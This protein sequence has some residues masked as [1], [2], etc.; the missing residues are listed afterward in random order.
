MD[1]SAVFETTSSVAEKTRYTAPSRSTCAENTPRSSRDTVEIA[2]R[3]RRDRAEITPRSPRDR[4]EITP[5][6]RRDRTLPVELP[7]V[8]LTTPYPR[9][10]ASRSTRDAVFRAV[11]IS[12]PAWDTWRWSV[13]MLLLGHVALVCRVVVVG[14]RGVGLSC[15][16]LIGG[17]LRR[18]VCVI[19]AISMR[20]RC[21]SSAELTEGDETGATCV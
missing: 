9:H 3:S 8:G 15:C 6:S 5:R 17:L 4:A 12:T 14:A 7:S 18:H 19:W 20:S 10:T 2:P 11:E 21:L 13:V 1:T 16:C